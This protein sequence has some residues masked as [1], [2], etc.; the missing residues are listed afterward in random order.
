MLLFR[1]PAWT[2]LWP[3]VFYVS[4]EFA[5]AEY[6]YVIRFC[7]GSFATMPTFAGFY[8]EMW[9][10]KSMLDWL[11]PLAVSLVFWYVAARRSKR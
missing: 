8:P 10:R 11:L 5:Q 6:R 1:R 3:A 7:H 2:C 9:N 4:R